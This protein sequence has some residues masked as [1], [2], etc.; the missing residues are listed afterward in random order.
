VGLTEGEN[1][2]T[3]CFRV[4]GQ[5]LGSSPTFL[6]VVF[7]FTGRE[8]CFA[9]FSYS[10]QVGA[11]VGR[12]GLRGGRGVDGVGW[13]GLLAALSSGARCLMSSF[14]LWSRG[15]FFALAGVGLFD[16]FGVG[17]IFSVVFHEDLVAREV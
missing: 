7:E 1:W 13:S 17:F 16:L 3:F 2:L 4:D 10:D 14:V 15:C 8:R 11:D 5:G 6:L 12:V 9:G